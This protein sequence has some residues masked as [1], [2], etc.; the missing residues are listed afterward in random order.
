MTD[1]MYAALWSTAL[2]P[3]YRVWD[4]SANI[5]FKKY[6]KKA[7]V[8]HFKID[9]SEVHEMKKR[10]SLEGKSTWT[11]KVDV[12]DSDGALIATVNKTLHIAML[13]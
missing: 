7:L 9:W 6:S 1:P 12:H 5:E 4:L 13:K 11:K 10:L 2:G 3:K 8:S